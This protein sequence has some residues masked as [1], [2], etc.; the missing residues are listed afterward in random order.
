MSSLYLPNR[1]SSFDLSKEE[2]AQ[3]NVDIE[4][5]LQGDISSSAQP[6]LDGFFEQVRDIQKVLDTLTKLLK[7]LQKSNE[8]S[9]VVTKAAAMKEIK[10]RMEK[11]V[12]EVTKVARLGKSKLLQLNKDNLTNR[13]KA[14]FGKGSAVDRTRISTTNALTTK[15]RERISEFQTLRE[16]IQTE[17]REVVERRI[18]TGTNP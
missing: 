9:K 2:R 13:E 5:G 10:K 16:A 6:G 8:E 1:Q 14:G 15:F 12:N 17:Y 3:G 4:L 7:D 11:D 18:F